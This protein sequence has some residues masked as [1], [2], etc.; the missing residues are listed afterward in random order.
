MTNSLRPLYFARAP[1]TLL[2]IVLWTI[3]L[4]KVPAM[5]EVWIADE[6]SLYKIDLVSNRVAFTVSAS[7][8]KQ[9]VIDPVDASVWTLNDKTLT[10]RASTGA[11][12]IEK[13]LD[14]LGLAG[15][16]F[17]VM[18][19]RDSSVWAGPGKGAQSAE[20]LKRIDS[21]G[22]AVGSITAPKK[23]DGLLVGL[24]RSVWVLS[25]KRLLRY[26]APGVQ[27]SS[28]DL[29]SRMEGEPK[30]FAVDSLGAWLWVSAEKRIV[31]VDLS[32]TSAPQSMW[33]SPDNARDILLDDTLGH[34]WILGEKQLFGYD[35]SGARL[36]TVDLKAA[37]IKDPIIGTFDAYTRSIFIGY[38]DGLARFTDMG[39]QPKLIITPRA[40]NAIGVRP[41]ILR[42][43]LSIDSPSA[44]AL[45][46][47]VTPKIIFRI[48][49]QC[50]GNPCGFPPSFLNGYRISALLNGQAIGSTFTFDPVAGV[51]SYLPTVPLLQ[52]RHSIK[53][54]ATD[55]FGRDSNE[56]TL[57]F[58]VDTV[59]PVFLALDPSLAVSTNQASR[60]ISGRLNEPGTL[61][62]GATN[63]PVTNDG[64]FGFE[65]PLLNGVNSIALTA[66]DLAGNQTST[67]VQITLDNIPPKISGIAPQDGS[68][69]GT[70]SI[71]VTGTVDK[72][73][74]VTLTHNG[75]SQM[76]TNLNFSFPINLLPGLNAV[77]L[78]ATDHAGNT[79]KTSINVTLATV[80]LSTNSIANPL[81]SGTTA[82]PISGN[83]Q[84]PPNTRVIVNATNA[85]LVGNGF[86]ANV[87]VRPGAN[88]ITITATPP[89]GTPVT[90][91]ITV[92]VA[93]DPVDAPY[94][95][96][97][98][99]LQSALL[100]GNKAAALEL[101][102]A[103]SRDRYDRVFSELS[104]HEITEVFVSLFRLRR[105]EVD[106]N[107]AEY[108]ANRTEAG[109]GRELG[110]FIY[111]V[112][113]G[114]GIWRISTM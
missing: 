5:A 92:N 89:E 43:T 44:D 90:R 59:P 68:I 106:D 18:D 1:A 17:L 29:K 85:P 11:V 22:Q 39:A 53:A 9:I 49:P 51:T 96:I 110:F 36:S 112:K 86:S 79:V 19:A 54:T 99:G 87:P 100:A 21:A 42:S 113:D 71:I 27:L 66:K 82:V 28:I 103:D 65:Q 75:A 62:I 40:V 10:K 93:V 46:N 74:T 72:L 73:A 111:F 83:V 61:K 8:V 107:V 88:L 26:S 78:R 23:I 108:F 98:A 32:S 55:A 56:A 14:A 31:R 84:G 41:F 81:P 60:R 50:A 80:T 58:S 38:Q 25:D 70:A 33:S 13:S 30:L 2:A 34:L 109:T 95:E 64:V 105:I 63:V 20:V 114:D 48:V 57:T 3:V 37:G 4:F 47:T 76:S 45:V 102:A 101:I 6:K 94:V 97:W 52:G 7:K 12:L 91:T 15:A 67:I 35:H 69:A 16:D 77:E 104:T 24:D